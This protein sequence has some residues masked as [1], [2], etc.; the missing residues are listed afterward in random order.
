MTVWDKRIF[1][2]EDN[3][4]N[5]AAAKLL[6][7]RHG[8][9][10]IG[11]DRWGIDLLARLTEFG[12]VDLVLLDLMFPNN[13]NGLDLYDQMRAHPE[14]EAVPI[15]ALSAKDPME[16]IPILKAKG[17]AGFIP[18]PLDYDQFVHQVGTIIAGE[19]LWLVR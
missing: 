14:W 1:I 11:Y 4:N 12:R 3:P 7:E 15:V 9:A 8:A 16:M 18:K 6:L 17:F 13:V 5:L 10:A 2:V 19:Q